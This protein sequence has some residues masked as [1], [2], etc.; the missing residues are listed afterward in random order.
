M[1]GLQQPAAYTRVMLSGANQN[2]ENEAAHCVS[3]SMTCFTHVFKIEAFENEAEY[4]VSVSLTGVT[5][6]STSST[7]SWESRLFRPGVDSDFGIV[8]STDLTRL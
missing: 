3:V 4:C 2:F 5:H 8:E 6:M 1:S 7:P